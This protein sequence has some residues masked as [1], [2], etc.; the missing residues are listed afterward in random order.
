MG[1]PSLGSLFASTQVCGERLSS[2]PGLAG[3]QLPRPFWGETAGWL[4]ES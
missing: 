1:K 4:H 2:C 3:T